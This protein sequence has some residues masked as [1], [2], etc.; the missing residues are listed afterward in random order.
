[1]GQIFQRLFNVAK[2][3]FNAW[4]QPERKVS[5]EFE[6]FFKQQPDYEDYRRYYQKQ[7]HS[8]SSSGHSGSSSHRKSREDF[9]ETQGHDPYEVLEVAHGAS[10]PDIDKAFRKL[11][12]KYHP[13]R[14][15]NAEER[16]DAT[17]LMSIINA[18]YSFLKQKHGKK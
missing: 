7:Y 2:A 6:D 15:Q 13:D 8:Y 3:E 14:F 12:R 18:S 11:A 1:M 10:M 4:S 16:E 9:S 17:K 5:Q